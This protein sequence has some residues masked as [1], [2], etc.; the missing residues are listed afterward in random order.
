MNFLNLVLIGTILV[1]GAH[2]ASVAGK[3]CSEADK[4]MAASCG[5]RLI[6]FA[7]KAQHLDVEDDDE[8]AEFNRGCEALSDCNKTLNHCPLFNDADVVE[9]FG[10]VKTYCSIIKFVVDDFADCERKLDDKNLSCY[11]DWSPFDN[12][13]TM[14]DPKKIQEVCNNFFGKGNCLKKEVTDACGKG[15]WEKL[16]NNL[17]S[18]N[19]NAKKCDF[20]G[21]I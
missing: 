9:A 10:N 17:L 4:M 11:E 20:T 12:Y 15:H 7:G 14:K 16:K 8:M 21:I 2:G 3:V 19:E 5:L 1:A 6:D 18:L 13:V